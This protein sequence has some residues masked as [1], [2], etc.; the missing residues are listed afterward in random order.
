MTVRGMVVDDATAAPLAGVGINVPS[1]EGGAPL[2]DGRPAVVT[3]ARGQFEIAYVPHTRT[4]ALAFQITDPLHLLEVE[5][6]LVPP[7]ADRL[8]VGPI[9]L[10]RGNLK[11]RIGSG[12]RGMIGIEFARQGGDVVLTQIRAN[13]PAERAGLRAGDSA[14][15]RRRSLADRPGAHRPQLRGRRTG[16][17]AHHP[18]GPERR[19][20]TATGAPGPRCVRPQRQVATPQPSV[21]A[22]GAAPSPGGPAHFCAAACVGVAGSRVSFSVRGS[23]WPPLGTSIRKLCTRCTDPVL[24][25]LSGARHPGCHGDSNRMGSA[26]RGMAGERPEVPK[27]SAQGRDFLQDF[28]GT[29]GGGLARHVGVRVA[30]G[31]RGWR[32]P[33]CAFCA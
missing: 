8:D 14:D 26:D 20:L 9:R 27:T 32:Q 24:F 10:V 22:G 23:G 29:G 25:K 18:G 13:T 3:D 21:Q 7:S 30:V 12:Q 19:S 15:L 2:R 28:F 33:G 17:Q 11:D 16:G 5:Y 4:L 6:V 1:A 31:R